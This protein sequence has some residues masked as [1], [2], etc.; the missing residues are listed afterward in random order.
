MKI[1]L[2]NR[3]TQCCLADRTRAGFELTSFRL[4]SISEKFA[5]IQNLFC[6]HNMNRYPSLML[7]AN[8]D[9]SIIQN[10]IIHVHPWHYYIQAFSL[11][12]LTSIFQIETNWHTD[13][14]SRWRAFL[15]LRIF[16]LIFPRTDN[17]ICHLLTS[18]LLSVRW[19]SE[20]AF[21]QQH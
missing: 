9:L 21:R 4:C 14:D 7:R 20:M 2:K 12:K 5:I 8:W 19:S 17:N 13:D 10:R 15:T 6:I 18:N 3:R 16:L 1:L 11:H